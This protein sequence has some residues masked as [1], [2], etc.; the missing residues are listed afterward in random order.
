MPLEYAHGYVSPP[1]PLSVLVGGGGA[2]AESGTIYLYWCAENAAGYTLL[3]DAIAVNYTP[4][5]SIQVSLPA[6]AR[7][8]GT[9]FIFYHLAASPTP[10]ASDAYRIARWKS[11]NADGTLKTLLPVILSRAAHLADPAVSAAPTPDDLPAGSDRIPGQTRL[12][13]APSPEGESGY[14]LY[15]PD[16]IGEP[17]GDQIIEDSASGRWVRGAGTPLLQIVNPYGA[18]G[19]AQSAKQADPSTAL[20][21]TY[22]PNPDLPAAQIIPLRLYYRAEEAIPSGTPLDLKLYLNEEFKPGLLDRALKV[23]FVG[24]VNLANGLLDTA[25]PD[26]NTGQMDGIGQEIIWEDGKG[27]L[28]FPKEMPIGFAYYLLIRAFFSENQMQGLLL[29][30]SILSVDLS[31]QPLAGYKTDLWLLTGDAVFSTGDRYRIKPD[32]GPAARVGKGKPIVKGYTCPTQPERSVLGM[33]S[34]SYHAITVDG[35]GAH[36]VR[37]AQWVGANIATP[38]EG[39]AIALTGVLRPSEAIRAFVALESG[40]SEIYWS[41]TIAVASGQSLRV[42]ATYPWDAIAEEGIIKESYPILGGERATFNPPYLTLWV[43]IGGTNIYRISTNY[44]ILP[45]DSQIFL[46]SS[47]DAAEPQALPSAP[48]PD[49]C[50]FDSPAVVI[51]AIAGGSLPADSYEIGVSYNFVGNTITRISHATS[52]GCLKELDYADLA[53]L[54][55]G[56]GTSEGDIEDLILEGVLIYG[57]PYA[58]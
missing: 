16:E 31:P 27:L 42:T 40:F 22:K 53:D 4:N 45:G 26:S 46:V 50:L 5:Q 9:G 41:E 3:S 55:A 12:V 36:F 57:S 35:H 8:A 51:E 38:L 37:A 11:Y 1:S 52:L 29:P 6:G 15:D 25:D 23:E 30:G 14:Y 28:F 20:R 13:I 34:N 32:Y 56:G 49:F 47:L 17:D 43:R 58:D 44:P 24:Y 19:C 48:S 33:S 21:Q 7:T 39:S 10:D 18:G 54:K 2:F